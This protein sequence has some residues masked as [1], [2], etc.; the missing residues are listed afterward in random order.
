MR[1]HW[2]D[3]QKRWH[4]LEAPLRP[5]QEVTDAVVGYVSGR[6]RDEMVP[7]LK[8]SQCMRP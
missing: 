5:N 2:K 1:D 6:R 7:V 8:P 4:L 3:Y